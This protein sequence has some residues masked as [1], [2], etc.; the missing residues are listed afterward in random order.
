MEF[1]L[2][3]SRGL[4]TNGTFDII[5]CPNELLFYMWILFLIVLC[6]NY[7]SFLKRLNYL[8]FYVSTIQGVRNIEST[9]EFPHGFRLGYLNFCPSDLRTPCRASVQIKITKVSD[10]KEFKAIVDC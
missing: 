1:P 3:I 10:F 8:V 2:S 4:D 6:V 9:V 7:V 5:S